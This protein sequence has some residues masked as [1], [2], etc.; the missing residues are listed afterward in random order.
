MPLS[1]EIKE[2]MTTEIQERLI[3][4]FIAMVN[5]GEQAFVTRKLAS[6]LIAI[7]RHHASP[8]KRTLWQL[9]ASLA[10]GGYISEQEAQTVDFLGVMP[11]LTTEQAT[12]LLFF[13]VALAEETLRLDTEPQDLVGPVLQRAVANIKDGFLLVQYIMQQIAHHPGL[14]NNDS[15]EVAL[16]IEA[17]NSWKVK[18]LEVH[19]VP[20]TRRLTPFS[21]ARLGLGSLVSA[22]IQVME[23]NGAHWQWHVVKPSLGCSQSLV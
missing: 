1:G 4:H 17:M 20:N 7:F 6:S 15:P 22:S 3:N 10:H 16:S 12:A 8:W 13:S 5:D 11:A 19:F 18:K 2:S 23:T 21:P 14:T 9:A